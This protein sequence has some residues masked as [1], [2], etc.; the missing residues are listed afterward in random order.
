MKNFKLT[1]IFI[2]LS[3]VSSLFVSCGTE[4]DV[5]DEMLEL[6]LSANSVAVGN[7]IH[8]TLNSSFSGD[9]TSSAVFFVNGLEIEGSSFTP[10]EAHDANE[11]YA[12]Y[13]G[14]TSATKTFASTEVIP[15]AYT[16][17]V[18]LEDYTGTWCGYCPRMAT[19]IKYLG[20]YDDRIIPVAIHC[21]GAPTDP[22]T[23]EFASDMIKPQNYN[24]QG[25]PKGKYN[26]IFDL[27]QHQGTNP[28]PNDAS[29]YYPQVQ[30]YLNQTAK[31]GL[32]INS[33][34]EGNNLN[35]KVKVGF[36]SADI[37]DARLVV[38][39]IEDGLKYNQVNYY[40]GGNS[41]CD[42]EYNYTAMPNPIPNFAQ[43]HV[44]LK[45]YTDIYGDPIPAAQ[46]AEGNV[47]TREFNVQL[48][49]NVGNVDNLKIVAFVLGD[50]DKVSNRAALNVQSAKVGT[51]QDF[52]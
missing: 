41:V 10:E 36:A 21:P 9:V 43:E 22:W 30:Q 23:Y 52:D 26:R 49:N 28:C 50:G 4:E 5:A 33:S 47:W 31:L 11:V 46:V 32:G 13:N 39:V 45:A 12:T 25:Q 6:T 44:L 14:K 15:S 1:H 19:I 2:L 27:D 51:T 20:E 7:S 34:V 17:K 48:P 24:A 8:F 3:F 29:I 40:A 38:T 18:L 42:P 35:I 37:E 16:Q